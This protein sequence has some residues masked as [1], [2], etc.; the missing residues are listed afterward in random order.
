MTIRKNEVQSDGS[1]QALKAEQSRLPASR[2]TESTEKTRKRQIR[3]RIKIHEGST[4]SWSYESGLPSLRQPEL[5]DVF[6]TTDHDFHE[7][8]VKSLVSAMRLD[9]GSG[10]ETDANFM[11]SVIKSINPRDPIEVMLGAQMAAIHI[12]T[13]RLA[14]NLGG[15]KGYEELG[16]FEK[17]ARTFTVLLEALDRHRRNGEQKVTVQHQHQ[18]VSVSEGGQAIVGNI[19]HAPAPAAEESPGGGRHPSLAIAAGKDEPMPVISE[20]HV[21]AAVPVL[22]RH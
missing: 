2:P 3:T 10:G 8:M 17:F 9:G 7:G 13:M 22:H 6:T 15:V 14:G 21:D 11:L 1:A 12:W 19:T 5:A 20:R 18:H 16:L 4:I